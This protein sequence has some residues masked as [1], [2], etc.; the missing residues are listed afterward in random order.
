MKRLRAF[1]SIEEMARVTGVPPSWILS[2]GPPMK[3]LSL[4]L[5]NAREQNYVVTTLKQQ[6][7]SMFVFA[8]ATGTQFILY[9]PATEERYC[10]PHFRFHSTPQSYPDYWTWKFD[11]N[12]DPVQLIFDELPDH[13]N[14][15]VDYN[16]CYSTHLSKNAADDL[17]LTE[18]K[19]YVQTPKNGAH[20]LWILTSESVL[21]CL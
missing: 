2:H 14:T 8:I 20:G 1:E 12:D 3:V 21:F 19:D 17:N 18:D 6:I 7:E 16:I 13:I 4:L 10:A 5:S 11:D 15:L 9:H